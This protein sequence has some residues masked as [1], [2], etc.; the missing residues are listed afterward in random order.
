MTW[1][2][3][4]G[5]KDERALPTGC[6]HPGWTASE[7]CGAALS[8]DPGAL[9]IRIEEGSLLLLEDAGAF[10]GEPEAITDQEDALRF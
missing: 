3:S 1:S 6:A 8:P 10:E 9:D 2:S 7:R 5:A 4:L